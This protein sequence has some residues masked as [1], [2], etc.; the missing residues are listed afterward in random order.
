L[1]G[2]GYLAI[3]GGSDRTGGRLDAAARE[4]LA[5]VFESLNLELAGGIASRFAFADEGR[6]QALLHRPGAVVDALVML[7]DETRSHGLAYGLGWGAIS[8]PPRVV[9]RGLEGPCLDAGRAA[10]GRAR[11]ER[12]R[13]SCR[14]WGVRRDRALDGLFALLTAVRDSWTG[15]QAEIV[16][17]VRVS[18]TQ[19][20]AAASLGVSPSVVCEALAAARYRAVLAAEESARQLLEVFAE[21]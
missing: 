7:Q 20:E 15:R 17:R 6:F 5:G 12:R 8:A 13:V 14:G 1:S 2:P 18:T 19:R 4:H 9:A 16:A 3:V 21:G 11:G 10:F